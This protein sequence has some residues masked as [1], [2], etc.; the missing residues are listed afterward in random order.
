MNQEWLLIVWGAVTIITIAL[1]LGMERHMT[2][3]D[4]TLAAV[5]ADL[6][7]T[8]QALIGVTS[9]IMMLSNQ[10]TD[11]QA[12]LAS[13]GVPQATLDAATA[14]KAEADSIA[15]AAEA[16]IPPQTAPVTPAA[17]AAPVTTTATTA[18]PV[19]NTTVTTANQPPATT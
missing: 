18:E 3:L 15:A 8:K 17:P 9:R 5:K 14:L 12:Q 7:N 13:A 2:Q 11:L 1:Y 4:D 19:A 10:V 16:L 6:D